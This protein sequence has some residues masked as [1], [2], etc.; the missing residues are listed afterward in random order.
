MGRSAALNEP[1][2]FDTAVTTRFV[3]VLR[4]LTLV[5]WTRAPLVSV[6]V[7]IIDPSVCCACA[8]LGDRTIKANRTKTQND[9]IVLDTDHPFPRN[10]A[11][12]F[13]PEHELCQH[14]LVDNFD[15]QN[16]PRPFLAGSCEWHNNRGFSG[17]LVPSN[18]GM[19]GV[20]V[21]HLAKTRD[22]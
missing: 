21:R 1:S 20:R 14:P 19:G 10:P 9:W 6:T 5:P 3:P 15:R 12:L 16:E 17:E 18:G 13:N 8:T 4:I 22:A 7:P 2:S 11:W